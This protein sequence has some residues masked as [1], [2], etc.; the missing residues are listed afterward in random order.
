[1]RCCA[2]TQRSRR[3]DPGRKPRRS[4]QKRTPMHELIPLATQV[5]ELLK[6]RGETVAIAESSAGGLI[7]AALLS[8]GGA[9]AY[10]V[11]GTVVY[12]RAARR[13][14]LGITEADMAGFR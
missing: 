13:G 8:I 3:T 11:G 5:G 10:F 2:R 7:A 1:M 9:S 4:W 12:T 14:L 6:A